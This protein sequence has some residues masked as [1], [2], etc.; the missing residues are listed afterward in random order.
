MGFKDFKNFFKE[1]KIQLMVGTVLVGGIV[2]LG[3]FVIQ[4]INPTYAVHE[5]LTKSYCVNYGESDFKTFK[6]HFN[7]V[8]WTFDTNHP[9]S[10]LTHSTDTMI[11]ALL[12][13]FDGNCMIMKNKREL[14]K[15]N[16]FV[17]D[18]ILSNYREIV[19]W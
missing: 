17:E 4:S 16:E 19:E 11:H 14:D 13:S 3:S 10:L 2:Y 15:V 12:I 18:Y 5:S 6:K 1:N 7:K 9:E 8:E